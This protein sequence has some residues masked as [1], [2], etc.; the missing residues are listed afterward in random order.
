MSD[1]RLEGCVLR[2]GMMHRPAA[3]RGCCGGHEWVALPKLLLWRYHTQAS[4]C[5]NPL[6]H[7]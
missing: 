1:G 3:V 7:S 4:P 5:H 2:K 6:A